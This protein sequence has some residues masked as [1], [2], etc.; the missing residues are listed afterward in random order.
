[1][2]TVADFVGQLEARGVIL[3]ERDGGLAARPA[4]AITPTERE[5][6]AMMKDDILSYLR[7]RPFGAA[8]DKVSLYKLDKILEVAVPWSDVQ[9]L[10]APGCKVAKE[11]RAHD[12]KPGRIWCTCEILDLLLTNVPP[13]DARKIAEARLLFDALDWKARRA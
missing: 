2:T 7:G 5:V 9:L 6:L 13:E 4:R 1:M 10:I 8:W 12:P 3:R 11:L